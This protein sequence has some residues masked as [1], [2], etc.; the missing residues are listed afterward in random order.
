MKG[1]GNLHLNALD[2][3]NDPG[4]LLGKSLEARCEQQGAGQGI[5]SIARQELPERAQYLPCDD[6]INPSWR[7]SW[8]IFAGMAFASCPP[9]KVLERSEG[10][11]SHVA[12]QFDEYRH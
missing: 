12:L 3:E 8:A 4:E 2:A 10:R 11:L 7:V 1:T 6:R 9:D 5:F